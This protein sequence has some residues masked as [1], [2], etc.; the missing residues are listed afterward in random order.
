[1]NPTCSWKHRFADLQFRVFAS[2]SPPIPWWSNSGAGR[3]GLA[4]SPGA[5]DTRT[6]VKWLSYEAQECC[7]MFGFNG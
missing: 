1:M 5:G 6:L 7:S 3:G 4:K 2:N